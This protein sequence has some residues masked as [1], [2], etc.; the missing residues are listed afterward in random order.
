LPNL[1]RVNEVMVPAFAVLV[2]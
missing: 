1:L 2:T